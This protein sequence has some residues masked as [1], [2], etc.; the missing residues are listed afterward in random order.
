MQ[1]RPVARSRVIGAGAVSSHEVSSCKA[2]WK[3]TCSWTV[4]LRCSSQKG[5]KSKFYRAETLSCR[6]RTD[7]TDTFS[8]RSTLRPETKMKLTPFK[9]GPTHPLAT[10]LGGRMQPRYDFLTGR[11]ALRSANK[12]IFVDQACGADATRPPSMASDG[13]PVCKEHDVRAASR[14]LPV[15]RCMWSL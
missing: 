11:P 12:G 9:T 6:W 5:W 15:F 3:M 8:T 10:L 1:N 2:Y 13:C 7:L 14:H 4:T